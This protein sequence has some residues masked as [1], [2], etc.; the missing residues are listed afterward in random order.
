MTSFMTIVGQNMLTDEGRID[1]YITTILTNSSLEIKTTSHF[2]AIIVLNA[3]LLC[4][5]ACNC[6]Q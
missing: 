5:Y 3:S 1:K 6:A 2:H 4:H